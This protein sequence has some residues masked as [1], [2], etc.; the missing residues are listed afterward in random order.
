M[1]IRNNNDLLIL[2]IYGFS[3]IKIFFFLPLL[4]L[5]GCFVLAIISPITSSMVKYYEITKSQHARD[6]DHLVSF[7]K[8]GLWIK[9][10]IS[11]GDRIIS[12]DNIKGTELSKM[13]LYLNLTMIIS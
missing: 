2:K 7:N 4:L 10:P 1:K 11:K 3:N 9:E 6:I 5:L 8:N 12:A 13:Q